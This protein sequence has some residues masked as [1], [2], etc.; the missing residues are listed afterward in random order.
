MRDYCPTGGKHAAELACGAT[1]DLLE[2]LFVRGLASVLSMCNGLTT[3]E[4]QRVSSAF[5]QAKTALLTTLTLKLQYW[6]TLPWKLAGICHW[7]VV[8]AKQCAT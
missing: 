1:S 3:D 5:T 4:V 8:K 7:T 6:S 2:D